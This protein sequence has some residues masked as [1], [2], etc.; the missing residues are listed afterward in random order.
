MRRLIRPSYV[1]GLVMAFVLTFTL[2]CSHHSVPASS[3]S[4]PGHPTTIKM[5]STNSDQA[6]NTLLIR[7]SDREKMTAN[8]LLV[9][10]DEKTKYLRDMLA[11]YFEMGQQLAN[12]KQEKI[13]PQAQTFLSACRQ[14]E[15]GLNQEDGWPLQAVENIHRH[16]HHLSSIDSLPEARKHYGFLSHNLLDWLKTMA[17]PTQKIYGFVCGMAQHVPQKGVWLQPVPEVRNPYFGS[18]MP[19]CYSQTFQLATASPMIQG[20]IRDQQTSHTH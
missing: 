2:S 10:P 7:Q 19:T 16:G 13:H 15:E 18:T 12:D 3:I 9:L 14:L 1:S 17:L 5:D 6:E 4:H 20:E 11:A 8:T